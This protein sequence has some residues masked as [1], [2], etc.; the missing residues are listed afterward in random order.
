MTTSKVLER[1]EDTLASVSSLKIVYFGLLLSSYINIYSSK[2]IITLIYQN[3][4]FVL[5]SRAVHALKMP[6]PI[7]LFYASFFLDEKYVF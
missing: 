5:G 2:G 1:Q 3:S 4:L 7:S 6:S